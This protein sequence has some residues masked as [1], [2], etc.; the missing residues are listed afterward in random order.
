M[1]GSESC[2]ESS[3]GT[4]QHPVAPS[5]FPPRL[6]SPTS[7]DIRR[8]PLQGVRGVFDHYGSAINPQTLADDGGEV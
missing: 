7:P 2:A 4:Q 1:D 5:G 3:R 6:R 8:S